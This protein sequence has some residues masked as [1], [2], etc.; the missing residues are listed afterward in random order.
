MIGFSE[1]FRLFVQLLVVIEG[2]GLESR[3]SQG[4]I[5]V[6]QDK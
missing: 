3:R 4:H 2:V 6:E 5:W 1:V